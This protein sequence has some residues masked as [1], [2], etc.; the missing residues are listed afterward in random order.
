MN[1]KYLTLTEFIDNI[2]KKAAEES[3]SVFEK[4]ACNDSFCNKESVTKDKE[5]FS[6]NNVIPALKTLPANIDI[7]D[8]NHYII[9]DMVNGWPTLDTQKLF[10]EH[11]SEDGYIVPGITN[12][13]IL[14]IL[15]NRYKDNP[16]KLDLV[17]QLMN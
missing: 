12:Q 1:E 5:E 11:T 10:F 14:A 7:V 17:R 13:Q 4:K 8:N 6:N 15:Y 9:N 2:L 16:K 3:D